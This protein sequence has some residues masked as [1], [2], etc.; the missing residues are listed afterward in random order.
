MGIT[1]KAMIPIVRYALLL[2]CLFSVSP[3]RKKDG[4]EGRQFLRRFPFTSMKNRRKERREPRA[5]KT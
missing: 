4:K 2:F 1:A 5:A 3:K